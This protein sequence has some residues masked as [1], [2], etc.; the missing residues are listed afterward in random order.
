MDRQSFEDAL[1]R[2]GYD[3]IATNTTPGSKHNPEHSH[4]YDVSAMVIDG[5]LTL[6]WNGQTRTFKP[7]ETFEM[8]RGCPHAESYGD[9][10]AVTL[11]G[12]KR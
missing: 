5:A 8:A 6:S 4:P 12:R 7:G 11:F 1:R 9:E 10:G 2:D 3:E